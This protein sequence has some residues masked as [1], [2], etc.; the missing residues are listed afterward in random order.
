MRGLIHC[1]RIYTHEERGLWTLLEGDKFGTQ[2]VPQI[3][4]CLLVAE[5][6]WLVWCRDNWEMPGDV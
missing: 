5:N 4:A 1:L 2:N 3:L 6:G